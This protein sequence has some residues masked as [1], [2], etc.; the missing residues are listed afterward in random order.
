MKFYDCAAHSNQATKILLLLLSGTALYSTSSHAAEPPVVQLEAMTVTGEKT[1]RSIIDTATAVTILVGDDVDLGQHESINELSARAPNVVTNPTGGVNIRGVEGTGPAIGVQSFVSGGRPRVSTVIDGAGEVWGGQQYL[2]AGLWDVEQV[3]I[4][5]GPQSTTLGRNAIGGAVVMN[6]KNPTFH[7]EGAVRLGWANQDGRAN[8]AAMIS[9]PIVENELA[10]RLAADLV[11]GNSP[12]DYAGKW[13]WNPSEI[14]HSTVRGKLLWKPEAIAGLE[15]KLTLSHRDYVGQYMSVI[16]SADPHDMLYTQNKAS[17]VRRQDSN[18]STATLESSYVLNENFTAHVSYS[19]A[20]NQI[21]FEQRTGFMRL[22]LDEQSHT[23]EG[24]MV[25]NLP[26]QRLEGVAGLYFYQRDQLLKAGSK[27]GSAVNNVF[28]GTDKLGTLA[29]YSDLSWGLSDTLRVLLGARVERE[30]QDRN[31]MG[32]GNVPI[33]ADISKTV[34]LPKLGLA[35]EFA[36]KSSLAF[37]VREGYNPGAGALDEDDHFYQYAS[38]SVW[39]YELS[40]KSL[41]QPGLLVSGNLFYNDYT[42]YQVLHGGRLQNLPEGRTY[43][44]ELS[45]D[46]SLA[47]GWQLYGSLGLLNSEV[48]QTGA[49]GSKV[50][51]NQFSYAP[52][53]TAGLGVRKQWGAWQFGVDTNYVAEYFTDLDNT[54]KGAAGNYVLTHLQAS[55]ALGNATVRAYVKNLFDD[56]VVTRRFSGARSNDYYVG[57]PR[58]VGMNVEYRF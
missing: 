52:K 1:K 58:T 15:A 50:A 31:V 13:P 8:V 26:Q 25:F 20:D 14:N 51:G 6:T 9:A 24:R 29:M 44:L 56:D 53:T 46:M 12:I 38:E 18:N 27:E 4:L 49:W 23:V 5:R 21:S 54:E 30:S 19:Y 7:R 48:Q 34:F 22:K 40:A 33:N 39:T 55:Y 45:A 3:E 32:W 57:S 41:V 28:D 35:W 43:G 16:N 42:D 36:P 47:D 11:R 17:N 10:F 2:D 37:T